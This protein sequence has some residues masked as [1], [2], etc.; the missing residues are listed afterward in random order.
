MKQL[1]SDIRQQTTQ[2][3]D[4]KENGNKGGETYM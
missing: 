1:F 2:D 4:L 3:G